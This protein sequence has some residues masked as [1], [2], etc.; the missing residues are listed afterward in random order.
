MF[1]SVRDS[2]TSRTKANEISESRYSYIFIIPKWILVM[3]IHDEFSIY[4]E[5]K[6]A[7]LA[8]VLVPLLACLDQAAVS[9]SEL[10]CA[11]A[12]VTFFGLVERLCFVAILSPPVIPAGLLSHFMPRVRH[13]LA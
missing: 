12:L 6:F 9:L 4:R 5:P 13:S 10:Y 11:I 7:S 2:M 8:F 3:A 1:A